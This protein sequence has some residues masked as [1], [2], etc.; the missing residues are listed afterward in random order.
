MSYF[1]CLCQY[2]QDIHQR[3]KKRGSVGMPKIAPCFVKDVWKN[4]L[5]DQ[6]GFQHHKIFN[7]FVICMAVPYTLL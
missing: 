1:D 6:Q 7:G 4:I 2:A 3:G 5:N